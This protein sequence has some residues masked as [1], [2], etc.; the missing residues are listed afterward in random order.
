M[1]N[2][3][4]VISVFILVGIFS[5][6]LLGTEGVNKQND[7]Q[8]WVINSINSELNKDLNMN[9]EFEFRFGNDASELYFTY[10]QPRFTY[11]INNWLAL[12]PGYRQLFFLEP[13]EYE[14]WRTAFIPLIDLFINFD[15]YG[16]SIL[17]RN[18]FQYNFNTIGVNF[19]LYRNRIRLVSP[20]KIGKI[21]FN[22]IIAGEIFFA[23]RVGL[24][25]SRASVGGMFPIGVI[26]TAKTLYM[27]RY[28]KFITGWRFSHI[29][30]LRIDYNF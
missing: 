18:R 25:E 29:F 16:W 23:E 17:D 9:F 7:F 4:K 3:V 13:P 22:P 10:I 28:R 1:Q 24:F 14:K 20:Y 30:H 12:T 8:I 27:L 15:V 11:P 5:K 6:P 19:W 26:T 21:N 2:F